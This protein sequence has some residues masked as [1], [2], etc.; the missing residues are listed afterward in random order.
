VVLIIDRLSKL[1]VERNLA[2]GAHVSVLGDV[3]WIDHTRNTGIAFSLFRTHGS[4]VFVFDL[5][6]IGAILYF[7]RRLPPA[8]PWLAV[9]LGLVLGGAMGNALDRVLSGAVTD[10]ID[11]RVWPVF[12]LADSAISVGALL[13]AWRLYAGPRQTRS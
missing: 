1:A 9:G 3:L 13:V 7:A 11:L 12:N 10:F 2:P 8:E 5:V 6:A 4:L